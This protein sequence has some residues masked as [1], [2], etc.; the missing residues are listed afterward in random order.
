MVAK[1]NVDDEGSSMRLYVGGCLYGQFI[2]LIYMALANLYI[3]QLPLF[4]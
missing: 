2:T 1:E 4:T 3:V